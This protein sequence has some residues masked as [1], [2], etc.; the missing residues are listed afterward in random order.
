MTVHCL[1]PDLPEGYSFSVTDQ[2][3]RAKLD[4]NEAPWDLPRDLKQDLLAELLH[5]PWNRY[6]QPAEYAM[7]KSD[8]ARVFDISPDTIA[9]TSG[10]DQAIEAAFL[11]GGGAGRRARWFEPTYP[12]IA[13]AAHRTFTGGHAVHLGAD[14]DHT[15]APVHALA[16]PAPDLVVF[17]SPNNP[18]GGLAP[19]P[20]VAAALA[21]ERRLVFV[22]EAYAD[23]SQHSYASWLASHANLLIGRSLS[24]S[25]LAG[26]HAGFVMGHPRVIAAIERMLTAP[27]HVNAWQL[28]AARRYGDIAPHVHALVREVMTERERMRARLSGL[29]GIEPRPSRANF[30]LFRIAAGPERARFIYR[31]LVEHGVRVRDVGGLAGLAGYL[32]VTVGTAAEN[33]CFVGALDEV[34][35]E[36]E[37]ASGEH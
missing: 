15:L 4:Q 29:S 24:K 2:P 17:V 20:A 34:Q 36:A 21:D 7:A 14:I 16:E 6:V 8:L 35:R 19:E 1:R 30:L 18:T 26:V 25:S 28:L 3:H 10:C 9:I 27:Y 22:D 12:Y 23:F 33:D 11:V 13:H 32:R 31:R 5:R 37:E